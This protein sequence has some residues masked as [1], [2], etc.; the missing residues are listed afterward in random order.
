MSPGQPLADLRL[1]HERGEWLRWQL[2]SPHTEVVDGGEFDGPV[3]QV[4]TANVIVAD[5]PY[6]ASTVDERTPEADPTGE[7]PVWIL[8]EGKVATGTWRRPTEADP[9]EFVAEDGSPLGVAPGR[10]WF[11]L[12]RT[13][14]VTPLT[15]EEIAALP[16]PD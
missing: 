2:G 12:A 5:I 4:G 8:S 3:Q 16:Q 14:E 9:W 13:G 1:N 6:S 15:A 10:T 7:G 11:V